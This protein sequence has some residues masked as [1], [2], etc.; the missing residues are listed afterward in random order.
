MSKGNQFK[1]LCKAQSPFVFVYKN[2]SKI[3]NADLE[4]QTI[5]ISEKAAVSI[6]HENGYNYTNRHSS[7]DG[8]AS[9]YMPSANG[10]QTNKQCF[11]VKEIPFEKVLA[12]GLRLFNDVLTVDLKKE[13]KKV[14]KKKVK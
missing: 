8:V 14:L 12:S 7:D 11:D 3:S 6:L 4:D 2:F 1:I 9:V 5:F 10:N 13:L